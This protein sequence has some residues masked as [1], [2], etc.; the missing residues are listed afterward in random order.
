VRNTFSGYK[1]VLDLYRGSKEAWSREYD[2]IA[3]SRNRAFGVTTGLFI[4]LDQ[5]CVD[6]T[7]RLVL[8]NMFDDCP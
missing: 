8:R 6:L 4:A 7:E 3:E 1:D 2:G 5:S